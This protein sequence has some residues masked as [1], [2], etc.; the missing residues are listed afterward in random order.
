MTKAKLLSRVPNVQKKYIVD[1]LCTKH[2]V[3]PLRLPPNW[4]EFNPIE[5]VWARAKGEVARKNLTYNMKSVMDLMRSESVAVDAAQWMKCEQHAMNRET[6][7][8]AGDAL[9][10]AHVLRAT[11]EVND[12]VD[13]GSQLTINFIVSDSEESDDD[14]DDSDD[15]KSDAEPN[16]DE[17]G[18]NSSAQV[19]SHSRFYVNTP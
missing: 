3:V 9:L 10:L 19:N 15:K 13:K 2:G 14:S 6:Q 17:L 7:A 8:I 5:L 11:K 4:C 18:D 1:E 12:G 16:G